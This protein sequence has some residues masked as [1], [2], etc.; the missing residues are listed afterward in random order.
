MG[1][2]R[3]RVSWSMD[4][5]SSDRILP[6]SGTPLSRPDDL[7]LPGAG[8]RVERER[9][10]NRRAT[11]QRLSPG[12]QTHCPPHRKFDAAVISYM[13]ADFQR[14]RKPNRPHIPL[15]GRISGVGGCAEV[16]FSLRIER[17][18]AGGDSPFQS[19][20]CVPRTS[21]IF[22]RASD[23]NGGRFRGPARIG[24]GALSVASREAGASGRVL[25]CRG[26]CRFSSGIMKIGLLRKLGTHQD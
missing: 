20:W 8:V 15:V 4:F 6:T 19:P 13:I 14:F 17:A 7:S 24:E 2:G 16:R 22:C 21:G 1:R 10:V 3:D 9:R 26:N 23:P 11:D 18:I 12:P 25:G 5:R